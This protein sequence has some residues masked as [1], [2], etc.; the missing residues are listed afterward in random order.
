M[1]LSADRPRDFYKTQEMK[2][3]VLEFRQ[4][5]G[6]RKTQDDSVDILKTCAELRSHLESLE[7]AIV[8]VE[9]IALGQMVMD[10]RRKRKVVSRKKEESASTAQRKGRVVAFRRPPQTH[11]QPVDQ[12]ARIPSV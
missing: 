5:R 3:A 7:K 2:M 10:T 8:A 4:D 11:D 1:S 9:Q 6:K 12:V